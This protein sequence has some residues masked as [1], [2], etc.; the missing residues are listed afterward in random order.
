M[1]TQQVPTWTSFTNKSNIF[2][3]EPLCTQDLPRDCSWYKLRIFPE[4]AR[5]IKEST[6]TTD[7]MEGVRKM[8]KWSHLL[9]WTVILLA[10]IAISEAL[11]LESLWS[12]SL[13]L[14]MHLPGITLKPFFGAAHA[15]ALTWNH[16]EALPWSCTCTCTYLESLWSLSLELHM[17]L[18]LPGITLKPFFGAAHAPA[19]TWNHSEALLWSCTCTCTYLESLWSSSLELHMHLYLPG[20]TLKLFFGAAHV[21]VLIWNH[22][23][24]LLWSCT[25]TCTYLESLWS[26]SLELHMHLYLPGITLKLFLG[27][28]HAPVLTWNHSE[29]LLWSCTCTCTYLE[30]LWSSSLELHMHLHLPGITLKLFLGAAHAPVLTWNHSE[31]LPWSCTCTCTYLESL[32]SSSLELHMHLHLPGIT[33]NLFLGAAHVPVLTWNHSEALPWSCTCTCT[34]LESLW[35]SS[36]MRKEALPW[37][38]FLAVKFLL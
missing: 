38:D 16:S 23:E 19:L 34:Y 4:T 31:A 8:K 26:S 18:H 9:S 32:W 28:A 6:F 1:V 11:L 10:I 3:N 30:S 33:L 20:I 15:P 24:A 7:L 5:D 22:S 14:H 13:E 27:A 35:S 17:H 36:L 37:I 25:C 29:A 2:K 12:S 21:P